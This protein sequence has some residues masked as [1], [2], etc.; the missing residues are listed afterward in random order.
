MTNQISA[1]K[2]IYGADIRFAI[3]NKRK[4]RKQK[5]IFQFKILPQ[6]VSP[7]S[8]DVAERKVIALNL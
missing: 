6:M 2:Y 1:K 3:R 5:I 4:Q 7:S 8:N